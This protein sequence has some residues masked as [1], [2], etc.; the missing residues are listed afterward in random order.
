M[1]W[2]LTDGPTCR[3]LLD[4]ELAAMCRSFLEPFVALIK[5]NETMKIALKKS[6]RNAESF[7]VLT[8]T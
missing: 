4:E 1:K 2:F 8:I 6:H 5:N 7:A 3:A